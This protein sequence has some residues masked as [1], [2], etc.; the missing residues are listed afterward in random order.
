MHGEARE[1]EGENKQEDALK[2][3]TSRA[4]PA[5]ADIEEMFIV[6]VN[7][8]PSYDGLPELPSL[9]AGE[10]LTTTP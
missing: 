3:T 1:T 7:Y 9:L 10:S 2:D 6:D 4:V 5:G 8:F